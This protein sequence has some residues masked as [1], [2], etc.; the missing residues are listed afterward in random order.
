MHTDHLVK[1]FKE[2]AQKK[3]MHYHLGNPASV[4]DI[5]QTQERLKI[6]FP[7]QVKMFYQT[8]NGVQVKDPHL[9][10]YCLNDIEID[11]SGKIHFATFDQKHRICFDTTTINNAGQ[12]DIVNMDTGFTV[13]LTMASFWSNKIWAWIDSKRT[14]WKNEVY[15]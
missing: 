14:I 2:R 11:E 3:G 1:N 6:T 13:T 8:V 12:W 9:D 4:E 7:S 5:E 10:I 15:C